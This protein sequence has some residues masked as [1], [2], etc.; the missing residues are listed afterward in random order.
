[1]KKFSS[2]TF[3]QTTFALTFFFNLAILAWSIS[4]WIELQVILYRSV[5]ALALLLYLGVLAGCVGLF[6]RLRKGG[7]MRLIAFLELEKL[8]GRLWQVVGGLVFLGVLALVPYVKFSLHVGEVIKKSTQDPVLTMIVFYWF[9]WWMV[10]LAAAALKVALQTSWVGGFA[11]ALVLLG[12]AYE[13]FLRFQ[14]VSTYPLSLGWSESSRYY[15]GSLYFASAIYGQRVPLSTLHPTRYFLQ[16]LPFLIPGLGLTASRLWQ[17][18]LWI[19]LSAA[20]AL[21]LAWRVF[22]LKKILGW[23][24]AGWFF[25]YLL[26][27]G[28]YYHLDPMIFAPLLFVSAKHPKRSLA[29]VLFASAWAGVSRVNWF[30]VPAMLAIA[31]YLMEEPVSAYRSLRRYLAQPV[32]WAVLGLVAAL[33]AQAAYIPLSGNA[34]NAEAFASSFFSQLLWYRLWPNDSYPLGILPA[35]I[36]V[37]GPLIVT[38]MLALR[39]K[40]ARLHPLRWIGLV[41]M[42]LVLL[43]GGLVVSVKIGGGGDLHNMDA[44]AV[45]VG[46]LAAYFLADKVSGESDSATWNAGA[47]PVVALAL[48]VPLI[49]LVPALSPYEKFN[50]KADHQ[51]YEQLV[52][53]VNQA[54]QHG[55]VLFINERH[56]VTFH[57]VDVPLVPKYEAVMLMEMA[58]SDNQAYLGH[59]YDDLKNR[60]FALIVAGKQNV[61]IKDEGAFADENNV[62]NL[63]V[64][65]PLLCYYQP[66]TVIT[67]D[68][69]NIELLTP[70][71]GSGNCQ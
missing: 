26:R 51:A 10:L 8:K 70:R 53:A 65:Q 50:Q 6:F 39:G 62:W 52:Q 68:E 19:L 17:V 60:R 3:W 16:S 56:L 54:G 58:M 11:A 55:P 12:I 15:Y 36:I 4:R 1:M 27:V 34:N 63:R 41:A 30:P 29:A 18:L 32:L 46:V 67:A 7:A 57:D 14:S 47:W 61:D 59:F 21:A 43:A 69:S 40:L 5:W 24:F 28:V 13:L 49:F 45:F 71:L 20:S 23:L 31:L 44:F 48:L 2:T 38:L 9:V 33:A 35:I 22:S 64:A 25:L 42:S 37:S 66:L